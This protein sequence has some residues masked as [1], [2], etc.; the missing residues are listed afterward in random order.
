M[1]ENK[2]LAYI[3]SLDKDHTH[4][5]SALAEVTVIEK[6]GDNDYIVELESGIRC[7]AIYNIF[8]GR[9]FADDVYSVVK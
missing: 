1:N 8:C 4:S 3:N 9:L 2:T 5:D 7:H 6:V